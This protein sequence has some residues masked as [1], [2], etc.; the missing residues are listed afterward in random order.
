MELVELSK[1]ASDFSEAMFEEE[2]SIAE[3]VSL[4]ALINAR[5]YMR[6]YANTAAP[7]VIPTS[8]PVKAAPE[9]PKIK[10]KS[11]KYDPVNDP[12]PPMN[13]ESPPERSGTGRI[14]AHKNFACVCNA[15]GKVQYIVNK[16]I[17]DNCSVETFRTSFTPLEGVVP[18]PKTAE[19]LNLDG[20]ISTDCPGCNA[21]KSLYLT[22]GA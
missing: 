14:L 2:L 20:K 15:C 22:G 6:I 1:M 4:L 13:R 8:V 21:N 12:A 10:P 3:M 18:L 17:P 19:I 11:I 5:V 9:A 7:E 16:D